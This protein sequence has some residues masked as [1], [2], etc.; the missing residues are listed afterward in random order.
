MTAAA[1]LMLLAGLTHL[2]AAPVHWSHAPA[3]GL[4]FVAAGIAQIVWAALFW[5][6]PSA[7]L[8]GLGI[9]LA[10]SL[11]ALWV[12]TRWLPAPFHGTPEPVDA[13]GVLS[14]LCEALCIAA[15]VLWALTQAAA[16]P[17]GQRVWGRVA[18]LLLV[19]LVSGALVYEAARA[20]E[21]LLPGLG[22]S[23]EGHTH[24]HEGEGE[25]DHEHPDEPSEEHE[26]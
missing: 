22:S 2:A 11:I 24:E 9:V 19:A 25:H 1:I 16:A 18:L 4:F 15:L 21:P 10:A 12:I 20:A 7:R 8:H 5:R 26:H 14:K 6:R 17:A 23:E 3:H 13:F